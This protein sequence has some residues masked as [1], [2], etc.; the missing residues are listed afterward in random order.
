MYVCPIPSSFRDRAIALYSSKIVDNKEILLTVS[1]T[2]LYYQLA[3]LLTL[4]S[5]ILRRAGL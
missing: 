1:N 5:I 2:A 4:P 3:K